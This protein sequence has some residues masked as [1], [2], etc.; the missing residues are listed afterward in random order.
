MSRTRSGKTPPTGEK[1]TSNNSNASIHVEEHSEMSPSSGFS[2]QPQYITEEAFNR[3]MDDMF[4]RF[5]AMFSGFRRDTPNKPVPEAIDHQGNEDSDSD[6][7]ESTYGSIKDPDETIAHQST[8]LN[9]DIG[10]PDLSSKS[11]LN[12]SEIPSQLGDITRTVAIPINQ[13][14]PPTFFGERAKAREWLRGYN[15]TMEINGFDDCQKLKRAHAYL[16][17]KAKTWHTVLLDERP[18]INWKTYK[19]EFIDRFCGP[20]DIIRLRKQLDS[21]TQLPGQE[22][23]DFAEY[24]LNLCIQIDPEMSQVDK[25]RR[26]ITGLN[27]SVRNMLN[28]N[29]DIDDWSLGELK[30]VLLK[31]ET[32]EQQPRYS[33]SSRTQ[34][35][36]SRKSSPSSPVKP[37]KLADWTCFNCNG[38]G[39]TIEECPRP[40]DPE[41]V[42]AKKAE[43][44]AS[45]LA[46]SNQTQKKE[47]AKINSLLTL[48]AISNLPCD[49]LKKPIITITINGV[50]IEGRLDSEAD[51][52]VLPC[53]IAIP[54]NLN[55]LPWDQPP[56]QT[57]SSSVMPIGM[58]SITVT[59]QKTTRPL[60]VAV[61]PRGS[62]VEPLWGLDFMH[63]FDLFKFKNEP[64]TNSD[65]GNTG[66]VSLNL[67]NVDQHPM[68]KIPFEDLDVEARVILRGT[69]LGF[70]DVF[71][72]DDADIG[73][74]TTI[75]HRIHLEDEK[76]V[77]RHPYR[78][79]IRIKDELAKTLEHLKTTGAIR[80]SKSP[81]AA[82][83]F[84][85]DKDHGKGKRL[86]AD[87]RY[88]NAKTIR[89]MMPMPHP[90][91]VFALLNGM[92]VFAKLDITSMFNQIEI[93]DR[94]IAKTAITT[95]FGLFECPLMP[96]GLVNAPA[97]A[98]R[99][100]K[101][102]LRELDGKSCFVYFDDVI[103]FAKDLSSLVERCEAV[104][105]RLREHNLK[106]KPAKCQFGVR[107]VPFLGH[108]ISAQGIS[109][110]PRRIDKVKYFP[111]PRNPT[112]VRS[113]LGLV[114]YMRKFI[115]DFAKIAKPLTLLT[116][117]PSEFFWT[118]EAQ[119]AFEIL[120]DKIIDA[121]IL[122]HFNPEASHELRTD[123][124]AVAMG[125]VLYQKDT[126]ISR[127]GVVLYWSKTLNAAQRNYSARELLAAFTA[128]TELQHYLHGKKFTLVTDHAALSLLKN[129][130]KDPH[131]RLARM[132]AQLQGFD[133]DVVYKAGI[134]HADADCMSR[135][136]EISQSDQ[137]QEPSIGP[138]EVRA[139]NQVVVSG[140]STRP[141]D[142]SS[143]F[144]DMPAKQR[145]DAYCKRFIEI[146]ESSSLS[147]AAKAEKAKNFTMQDG[148]LHRRNFSGDL[149]VV[150]P[151]RYR[152]TVITT[153]HDAPL[154]GHLGFARTYGLI[155]QRAFW[156]KMRQ[157]VKKYVASC[158]SCQKRKISNKR[159]QGFLHP[160]PIAEDIFDIVGIDL[161]TKLKTSHDGYNTILVCTDNLS[162]YAITVP[163]KN[164]TAETIVQAFFN[165]VIAKHGC[166]KIVIS[167][168]G[169]SISGETSRDFF[170]LFAIKRMRTSVYHPES[171]GQTERFNRTLKTSLTMYI[172]ESQEN[173]ADFV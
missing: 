35:S 93:D 159:R 87:Y 74:T 137:E 162:K 17:K 172:D 54:L 12:E 71:S 67:V 145:D 25:K 140:G 58:A 130:R 112:D 134:L 164:E 6:N 43:Y 36:G 122:V 23:S 113:F 105:Q 60:L 63:T 91:D 97:T 117:K 119:Q 10:P 49:E 109:R 168:Q 95:P 64:I 125:A 129:Q 57:A 53:D 157:D 89:Y 3:K 163:L 20:D 42:K 98:V 70:A 149:A 13:I 66:P 150:T 37:K 40:A 90:E 124:S 142:Q 21:A 31:F 153:C 46:A 106:L 99:L 41:G 55:V 152:G 26:I 120:R 167:D 80:E 44:R 132:V 147:E 148:L 155:K 82:P 39:H 77:A 29:R 166:P 1:D 101:E 28:L 160:M 24:I 15:T 59:Y 48:P 114:G 73:R 110:D 62:L 7:E 144:S 76:P 146:L 56:L 116:S 14:N 115:R 171:N 34:I 2:S 156:P 123:A 83:V 33:R 139:I 92:E 141:I 68:D 18:R 45:K 154:A 96:F 151:S 158:L 103:V 50:G 133:F 16:Q 75:K 9:P 84:F 102:V 170:R 88:L 27:P 11:F 108:I 8:K 22:P 72:K 61:M 126:E 121:P 127:T 100:M 78:V 118:T 161:I 4:S 131:Q 138:S 94:D 69:L 32:Q 30:R 19:K 104:L 111:V 47:P 173:W 135:L 165:H 136:V 51:M 169:S 38:K 65:I 81:F 79:P 128:I 52:T 5:E 86:V 107:S 85:V 143:D